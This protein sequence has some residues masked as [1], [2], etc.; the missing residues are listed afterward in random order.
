MIIV[1]ASVNGQGPCTNAHHRLSKHTTMAC[2][3]VTV[4]QCHSLLRDGFIKH[5]PKYKPHHR[6]ENPPTIIIEF[7]ISNLIADYLGTV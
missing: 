1:P 3:A 4:R 2:T 5:N 6:K 7:S